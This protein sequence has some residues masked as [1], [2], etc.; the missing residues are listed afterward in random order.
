MG[1]V[2][3]TIDFNAPMPSE[4]FQRFN[5]MV[6]TA[7]QELDRKQQDKDQGDKS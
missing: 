4:R 7:Q 2:L 1:M 3:D 5:E 6:E